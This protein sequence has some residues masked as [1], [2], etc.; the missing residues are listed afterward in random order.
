MQL[1][2]AKQPVV[3]MGISPEAAAARYGPYVVAVEGRCCN[4]SPY[5][6]WTRLPSG[7]RCGDAGVVPAAV[8]ADGK[9]KHV[10]LVSSAAGGA[11]G[12]LGGLLGGDDG[13]RGS[14]SSAMVAPRGRGRGARDHCETMRIRAGWGQVDRVDVDVE[15]GWRGRRRGG[16]WRTPRRCACGDDRL[17]A[18]SPGRFW[19]L[20][21]Q[22]GRARQK[23]AEFGEIDAN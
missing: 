14:G 16:V 11:G 13:R 10:V 8:V 1:I 3:A 5:P 6:G 12:L 20:T 9:V 17:A 2:V 23:R 22:T 15:G 7:F 21:L 4:A 19:S 18:Q